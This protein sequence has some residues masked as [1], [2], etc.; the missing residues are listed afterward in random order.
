MIFVIIGTQDKPFRR[1]IE[2]VDNLKTDEEIIVQAGT[3]EYVSDHMKIFDFCSM[4]DFNKYI[5]EASVVITH[6]G[7]GSIMSALNKD[8]TVV[9]CARLSS[10]GEHQNDHQ[11]QI[12]GNFVEEGYLA[13]FKQGD[14]LKEVIEQAKNTNFNKVKSNNELFI[15]QL[16]DYI[17]SI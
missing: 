6:G 1:L 4:E 5:S 10:L 16:K 9:A 12:I 17:D 2:A 8:K 14:D 11:Q 13:E 3:N 7:V 15:K